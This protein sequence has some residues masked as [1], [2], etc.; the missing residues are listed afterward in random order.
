M[1]ATPPDPKGILALDI[2]GT[3]TGPN[4][5]IGERT[6]RAVHAAGESGWLVTLATG[7]GWTSTKPIADQLALQ[8]P[9]VVYN[10]AVVRDSVT[11]EILEYQPLPPEV[12]ASLVNI[13]AERRLQPLVI[14]DIRHGE[15]L[16]TGPEQYDGDEV[17]RWLDYQ[18]RAHHRIVDRMPYEELANS[19]HAVRVMT[20]DRPERL[21]GIDQLAAGRELEFSVLPY[22]DIIREPTF[23]EFQHPSSTKAWALNLLAARFDL[24]MSDVVAVGDGV[25]DLEMLAEAGLGVAMG[26][27]LEHVRSVAALTIG[28]HMDDGLAAFIEDHLIPADGIPHHLRER[29]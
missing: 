12:V 7:R 15:R 17:R 27:A 6:R 8:V 5:E 28:H 25:N 21:K 26:N 14:E 11:A 22:G 10:G 1:R 3:L 9:L 20:F 29:G 19:G 24:T 23:V 16:L 13:L 18:Q 4:G 2:D